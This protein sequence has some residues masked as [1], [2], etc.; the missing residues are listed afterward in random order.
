MTPTTALILA[1]G[2]SQRLGRPK[3]LVEWQGRPL[4]EWVIDAVR[5]WPVDSIA[6]VLGSQEEEILEAVDFG[7]ALVVVNP[8]WEEGIASSLRVGL[9]AVGRD[10]HAERVFVVLADQP[11]IPAEVPSALIEGMDRSGKP[12]ALPKYRYQRSN[13]VLVERSLWT[14]LMSLEGDVGAS[15]LFQAHPEWV[16]EVRFDQSAPRDIDT[17]EDLS[18]LLGG[19]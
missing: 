1:A 19:H 6:V 17:P 8:E 7:D 11:D 14:R 9:D 10:L 13:P 18:D 15:R 3:Q 5:T 4:L 12:V 2:A 16:H